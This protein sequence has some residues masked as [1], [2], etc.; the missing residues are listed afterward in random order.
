MTDTNQNDKPTPHEGGPNGAKPQKNWKGK[1]YVNW[2]RCS[3][4]TQ[5]DTSPEGQKRMNDAFSTLEGMQW[6]HDHYAEGVSGSQTFNRHDIDE[7]IELH[8]TKPFDVVV[9]HDL[10]R[11][12]RGGIRHGNVVEDTLR[13]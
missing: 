6:V 11:M 3:N 1:Q 12:T 13:K 4:L 7:L 5:A 8:R 10:S 9:V 2:L